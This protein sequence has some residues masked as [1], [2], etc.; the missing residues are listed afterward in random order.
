MKSTFFALVLALSAGSTLE[1]SAQ[2]TT[3]TIDPNHTQATFEVRHMSLSNVRGAISNVTG[4]VVWDPNDPSKDSVHAVLSANTIDSGSAYRDKDIKG[5]D[6]FNVEKFPTFTFK[7]T[8]VKAFGKGLKVT[9]DLTLAGVTRS[10]VLDVT[11][12]AT[13]QKGMQGGLVTGMQATTTIKRTD[14]NIGTKYPNA[15]VS[16][17][18][19]ITIDIEMGQK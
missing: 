18:V 1:A 13:P 15:V 19:K 7:S 9:G 17:E 5:V 12:P 2:N 14:F 3:W 10:V 4:T 16:D 6:F 8:S 11:G